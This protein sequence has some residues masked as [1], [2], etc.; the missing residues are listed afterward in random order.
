MQN[1]SAKEDKDPSSPP[2]LSTLVYA[3][4][5][6]FSQ[7]FHNAVENYCN[8]LGRKVLII[9]LPQDDGTLVVGE[10]KTKGNGLS[11]FLLGA[12]KLAS[13]ASVVLPLIAFST[14]SYLR[15]SLKCR[16][17]ERSLSET[18]EDHASKAKTKGSDSE[19]RQ[20]AS[21]FEKKR[22]SRLRITSNAFRYNASK[23]FCSPGSQDTDLQDFRLMLS[24]LQ[25]KLDSEDLGEVEGIIKH[26][27]T[28]GISK[29]DIK[30]TFNTFINGIEGFEVP[31]DGDGVKSGFWDL[32]FKQ[33]L[34]PKFAENRK[35]EAEQITS[36]NKVLQDVETLTKELDEIDAKLASIAAGVGEPQRINHDFQKI[37]KDSA[38]SIK[39]W[40]SDQISN[41]QDAGLNNDSPWRDCI[42]RWRPII[43]SGDDTLEAKLLSAGENASGRLEAADTEHKLITFLNKQTKAFAL[44]KQVGL[45]YILQQ[46]KALL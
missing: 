12:L 45:R 8:F 11:S 46:K 44:Q 41:I 43:N 7:R 37:F 19:H 2:F 20:N 5:Q 15:R 24:R 22:M 38:Y 27:L 16:L 21:C 36:L 14:K 42:E 35:L 17:E 34:E 23:V 33:L 26:A 10:E 29:V 40:H 32:I 25:N 28:E 31:L 4:P 9:R 30:D 3:N 39:I 13:Y 6:N 1:V 18:P